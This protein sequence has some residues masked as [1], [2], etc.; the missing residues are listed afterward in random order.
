MTQ[1]ILVVGAGSWGTAL[2]FVLARNGHH[3]LLW[4]RNPE[5][6]QQ[7]THTRQNARFLPD[8]HFPET[9]QPIA[10][11]EE[12]I[13]KVKEIVLGIPSIAFRE[14]L[15]KIARHITK[16]ARI[17]WATKGLESKTGLLLHQVAQQ[18]LGEQ[19][20]LAVLSGPSF[21]KEVAAGLPTA[22]TIAS[23]DTQYAQ[24][25]VKLFHNQSFRP[26]SSPDIIGVQLG[27]AVKNIMAIAAG[28]ADGLGFGANTRTALITRGLS[29]MVRFG[30][31]QG[32]KHETFMGLA[33]LGDLLL[34]STD[35]QSRN[36]RF[37]Y[38]L[39]HG[40]GI[41]QAQ[42]EIGQVVEG[43]RAAG[44]VSRRAQ[45]LGIDMPIVEQVNRVL[46]G[47]CT[48]KEAVQALLSRQLKPEFS[49]QLSVITDSQTDN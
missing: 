1:P 3:V 33:C 41:S 11:L 46:Q 45:Q 22:V 49:Y 26:Y 2:A 16:E 17:C 8:E 43:V 15:E 47:L 27:G 30:M 31:A 35:N 24:D 13:P 48:P 29:E 32:G 36:R 28:I 18:V 42:K 40:S 19:R 37:G 34:T 10:L 6:V 25:L 12:A 39:A 44:E 7:M 21:A 9:L 38:A 23:N 20:A 5:H 14:I 4:G